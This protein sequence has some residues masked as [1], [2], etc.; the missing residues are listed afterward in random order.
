LGAAGAWWL[1][2]AEALA[3]RR[4]LAGPAPGTAL[5]FRWDAP[6]A[7]PGDVLQP[8]FASPLP[9]LCAGWAVAAV[10]LPWLVR[11]RPPLAAA[12]GAVG[13]GGALGGFAA[14]LP[15][16]PSGGEAAVGALVAAAGALVLGALGGREERESDGLPPPLALLDSP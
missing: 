6:R 9:L 13:W 7:V 14:A 12:I 1:L 16:G 11:G 4:L 5:A 10:V 3:G 2:L 15:G 8:L